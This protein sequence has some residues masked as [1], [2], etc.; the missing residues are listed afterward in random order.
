MVLEGHR[1]DGLELDGLLGLLAQQTADRH[2]VC[3][4]YAVA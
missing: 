3:S 1:Q 4:M 2:A